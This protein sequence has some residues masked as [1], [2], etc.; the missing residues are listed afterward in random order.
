[1]GRGA[2]VLHLSRAGDQS[3]GGG[4]CFLVE[5][6]EFGDRDTA[7]GS[8]ERKRRRDIELR[9]E[10]VDRREPRVHRT[11]SQFFCRSSDSSS[12]HLNTLSFC[13][14]SASCC[15]GHF[16]HLIAAAAEEKEQHEDEDTQTQKGKRD[17]D[18]KHGVADS[19]VE[20]SDVTHAQNQDA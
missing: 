11:S 4:H 5:E 19:L 12:R 20:G 2:A 7:D 9:H 10:D 15:T 1:M 8:E 3:D 14:V 17:S 16:C 13:R 6:R 18:Q